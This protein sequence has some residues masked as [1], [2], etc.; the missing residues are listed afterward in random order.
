M[1]TLRNLP[2]V[3][4]RQV[5]STEKV[6]PFYA[7]EYKG[8]PHRTTLVNSSLRRDCHVAKPDFS[9]SVCLSC[10]LESNLKA[11]VCLRSPFHTII[12]TNPVA[13]LT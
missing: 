12:H 3:E 7:R 11:A 1:F 4:S 9:Q 2:T 8:S 5:L 10:F 6:P 13:V